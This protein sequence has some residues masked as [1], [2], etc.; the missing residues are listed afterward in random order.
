MKYRDNYY[1]QETSK[2]PFF[3]TYKITI[4]LEKL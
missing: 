4:F 1:E 3:F 2:T